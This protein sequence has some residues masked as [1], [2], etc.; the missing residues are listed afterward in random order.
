MITLAV[1]DTIYGAAGAASAITYTIFGMQLTAGTPTWSKL[2]QGQ[3][4]TSA[5]QLYISPSGTTSLISA[6]VLYNTT[7][8]A[9]SAQLFSSGS[10][11]SNQLFNINIPANGQV[12]FDQSGL[13]VNDGSG[14]SLW[15][16]PTVM[17]P[18]VPLATTPG[19]AGVTGS[20]V[21][22]ARRDHTHY[23]TGGVA[24]LNIVNTIQS[25]VS[26]V[27]IGVIPANTLQVGTTWRMLASGVVNNGSGGPY[28]PATYWTIGPGGIAGYEQIFV[29]NGV[30]Q[31]PLDS[32]VTTSLTCPSGSANTNFY[33]RMTVTMQAATG[34]LLTPIIAAFITGSLSTM[35]A[36]SPVTCAACSGGLV[37]NKVNPAINNYIALCGQQGS[38]IAWGI[39]QFNATLEIVKT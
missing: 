31:G 24:S 23:S 29:Y 15:T 18:S 32:Y 33:L 30:A 36:N 4:G 26:G 13:Q 8:A 35:F 10:S 25:Y 9:V 27:V 34:G 14:N 20:D 2:A 22:A 3:L 11:A 28:S 39:D 16:V 6:I 17:S 21:G 19:V 7:S 1:S 37:G 12:F 38:P 5:S